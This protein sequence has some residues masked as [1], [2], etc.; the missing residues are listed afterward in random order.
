VNNEA[1]VDPMK[2]IIEFLDLSSLEE[3]QAE[4]LDLIEDEIAQCKNNGDL[5]GAGEWMSA[6]LVYAN[7]DQ[8]DDILSKTIAFWA[9][10]LELKVVP[11]SIDDIILNVDEFVPNNLA[12][13]LV[14]AKLRMQH[15][16]HSIPLKVNDLVFRLSQFILIIFEVE[17]R[18]PPDILSAAAAKLE[19]LIIELSSAVNSFINTNCVTAKTPS[20]ELVRKGNQLKKMVLAGERPILNEVDVLLGTTFRKFCESCE[21][22]ETNRIIKHAP[23]LKEQAN[24]L[25]SQPRSLNNSV[26]WNLVVSQIAKHVLKLVDEGSKRSQYAITPSLKLVSSNIKLD[27][28]RRNREMTFSCRLA[29]TGEGRASKVVMKYDSTKIPIDIKLLEPR[30]PFEI[31]GETEQI[32]TFGV[33]LREQLHSLEVPVTWKCLTLT[34]VEH[35]DNDS[36]KIEQQKVE[37]N[38]SSL[39]HD[40]PY[41]VNPIRKHE[42][43]Y[44]RD[45]IL[46][47]LIYYA[48]SG[49]STFLW[50]QKRVGKTS[51]IQVLDDKLKA[52]DNLYCVVFR[53]GEIGPLHEGQIA[54]R[55][56]ERLYDELPSSLDIVVPNEQWFGLGM[57]RLIP[58]VE[59]IINSLPN[60]KFVAIIDEFD[61]LDPPFYTGERGKSFVK[62]LRSLSEVGLTFFFVGSERMNIIYER[63]ANELNKWVNVFLDCLESRVDCQNLIIQPVA[64]AIEYQPECVD[65]IIDYCGKNPFYMHLLC[66]EVFKRCYQ[67]QRT[68]ISESDIQRAK[69]TL[70]R[71][72]GIT[73]FSHLWDDNPELIEKEKQS[74]ENCLVLSCISLLGGSF[75]SIDELIN[76]QDTIDLSFDDKLLGRDLRDVIERL[77]SRKIISLQLDKNKVG[78][79]LPIFKDWLR[80]NAELNLLPRWREFCKKT[81]LILEEEFTA[82]HLYPYVDA[83]FPIAEDKLLPISQRLVYLGKQ[84]DVS[85]LR[86]WLKQFD[87]DIRIEIA[88]ELLKRLSEK[89][90]INDGAMLLAIQKLQDA[91][92]AIRLEIGSATWTVVKG[93]LANLCVTYMDSEMKSGATIAREIAKRLRPGKQGPPAEISAWMKNNV[94]KDGII[95]IVDDFAGSGSTLSKGLTKLFSHHEVEEVINS[96]LNEGRILCY[97]LYTFPE[98]IERLKE[99][100]PRVRFLPVN[101]F[102][103]D[104]RALDPSSDIFKD[105]SEIN[106][107]REMLLQIGRELFPQ[108]PLGYGDLGALVCFNNTIPNNTLPIFWSSGTVND[109]PW[110]PLF[111]RV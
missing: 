85:E 84:K 35:L 27:L 46:S 107:A 93:R 101:V 73:N 34:G 70:I 53:M 111:P 11:S 54:H 100:F 94:K 41:T 76:A 102:G 90:F 42:G 8:V 1:I 86:V 104:V 12:T 3:E 7:K 17:A 31:S 25:L 79:T 48:S 59:K 44:G 108:S 15:S 61:D 45:A 87:D 64:E 18:R 16:P 23:D 38:W 60:T 105:E 2:N 36:M 97:T 78:I 89:G 68:Y 99:E 77:Q 72:L 52:V 30:G 56:A 92:M 10:P 20:I 75:E 21:K 28:S 37:P 9:S 24:N 49:T 65:F 103:D 82:P 33:T 63:H 5:L 81:K 98:A 51:I 58:F 4:I 39:I 96:Y 55:I 88:Y 6:K 50:G 106:F 19:A 14:R 32:V 57:G 71:T 74:A 110:K 47:G 109:K 80:D 13:A 83:S 69:H 62:A 66:S 67:E 26:L 95:L 22:G 29:N 40:P 43:L 91:L